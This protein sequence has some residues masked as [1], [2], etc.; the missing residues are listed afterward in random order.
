MQ[1]QWIVEFAELDAMNKSEASTIKAFMSRSVD[2]YRPCYGRLKDRFPRQCV[3]G[4]TVNPEPTGYLKDATGARRFWSV[5]CGVGKSEDWKID[6]AGLT[7]VR[8]Q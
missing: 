3:F 1:G 7:K 4:G 5:A 6:I 2:I 8:D